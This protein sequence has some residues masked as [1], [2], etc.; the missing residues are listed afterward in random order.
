MGRF[1]QYL[2]EKTMSVD[3]ALKI[4][5]ITS[6]QLSDKIALKRKYREL[7]MQNHPD[8]GGSE[9][10]TK[11]INN[12]YEILSK[13]SARDI[14]AKT[15]IQSWKERDEQEKRIAEEVKQALLS[16]FHPEI[17]TNYFEQFSN[18]TKFKYEI[19]EVKKSWPGFTVEFFTPD[20]DTVFSLRISADIRDV[21]SGGLGSG[22][23][24]SYNVFTEAYGLHKNKK[25]KMS[26]SDWGFTRDHSFF[27][28]P[29]QIFP[30]KKMKDIFSG[31]TNKRKFAK[32]DMITFLTKKLG[33]NWDGEWAEIPLGED[34]YLMIFRSTFMRQ[35]TWG[36]N[37]IYQQTSKY[38]KSRVSQPKYVSFMEEESST[39]IFETIQKEAKKVKGDAKI[40]KTEQLIIQAYEAYKKS[41]GM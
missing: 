39:D 9:E 40:K 1:K 31:K 11:D 13:A 5:G 23:Q 22:D 37:G 32:R 41:H 34:Y 7:A 33:A 15:N 29:E 38:N 17:F 27:R 8:K 35:G 36:I 16:N 30:K 3:D 18:G 14:E 12:A 4:F 24:Y 21:M 25:Q 28:K 20:K 10:L 6:N 19:K 2:I 26:K